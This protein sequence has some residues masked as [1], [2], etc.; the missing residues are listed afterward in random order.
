[1]GNN[2]AAQQGRP[3]AGASSGGSRNNKK[4]QTEGRIF[5]IEG[6]E[7]EELANT[8]LGILLVNHLY[9][10]ILFDSSATHSFV[11]SEFATKKKKLA[12]ELNKMDV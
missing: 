3:P 9:A 11:N 6:E 1:M 2:L 12:S 4:P 7:T 8:V 10:R 5:C